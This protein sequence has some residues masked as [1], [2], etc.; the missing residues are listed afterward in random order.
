[1]IAPPILALVLLLL[2]ADS[3]FSLSKK[4]PFLAPPLQREPP[5]II[6]IIIDHVVGLIF[7]GFLLKSRMDLL[8]CLFISA[9]W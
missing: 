9:V 8:V 6:S 2:W 7:F 1:M 3:P 5:H 4:I